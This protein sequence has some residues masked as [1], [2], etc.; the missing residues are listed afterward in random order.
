MTGGDPTAMRPGTA[1]EG[2]K[3]VEAAMYVFGPATG[4]VLSDWGA[5]VIRVEHPKGDPVRTTAAWGYPSSMQGLSYLWEMGNRGKRNLAVDLGTARGREIV[6][7]LVEEADVFVTSLLPAARRKLGIDV[8]DVM[9]RNPRIVYARASAVGPRG[10]ESEN[11]GFDGITYWARSGAAA[12]V[13]PP[14]AP[15]VLS[16][17]GPGF[18]DG[19]SGMMLAGG[20]AAALYRRER[21]GRGVV[22][23]ASLLATG[24]WAMQP[25]IA[26]TSLSGR[27]ELPRQG[28]HDAQNPLSNQYRT[29]D[30]RFV[31]IAFL[32]S[33]KYWPRFCE[34][35][36]RPEWRDVGR[37]T[38]AT[39]RSEH[40]LE[41]IAELD[42]L[43]ATRTLA[44]WEQVLSHQDG[45]WESIKLP[46]EVVDDEQAAANGYVQLVARPGR[47]GVH[48]IAAPVQFDETAPVLR[49]APGN[50]EHTDE[51]LSALGFSPA[52]IAQ[53]RS[54]RTVA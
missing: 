10:P 45:P 30:G 12:S 13:T 14:D 39:G 38:D 37:W 2:V 8:D 51:I 53:L 28:H 5:D 11:G 18:G 29:A 46:G 36:G 23:D 33:D 4:A 41:L 54:D 20:I 17:P 15:Y 24:L 52:E 48:L 31:S 35:V 16:M 40:R 21:T 9:A 19:Q 42:T 27:P 32:Q 44:E 6:L 25:G 43:F 3:V 49:P 50:G 22:V 34:V 47:P 7:R 26:S 1:L